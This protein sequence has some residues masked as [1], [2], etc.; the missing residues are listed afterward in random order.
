MLK[1]TSL[2]K[3]KLMPN[4][5]SWKA[6]FFLTKNAYLVSEKAI[7]I[8]EARVK[9]KIMK[10]SQLHYAHYASVTGLCS[11]DRIN[12]ADCQGQIYHLSWSSSKWI[13]GR[14]KSTCRN[15]ESQRNSSKPANARS[16]QYTAIARQRTL[17]RLARSTAINVIVTISWILPRGVGTMALVC[18]VSKSAT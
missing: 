8:S 2:L 13:Q 4:L 17:F 10:T 15:Y 1:K 16:P 3:V 9:T 18:A 12:F 14:S 7:S 11:L 5:K 6:S